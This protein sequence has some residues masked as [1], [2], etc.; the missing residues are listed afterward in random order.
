MH[1]LVRGLAGSFA[2]AITGEPLEEPIDLEL[3]RQQHDSYVE[4]LKSLVSSVTELPADDAHPG[5]ELGWAML[6]GRQRAARSSSASRPLCRVRLTIPCLPCF[7]LPTAATDCCFIEDT[8]VVA[9]DTAVVTRI[10]AGPRQGEEAPVAE[11]LQALGLRLVRVEAPATLDG[12]DVLQLPGGNTI[13]VGLSRRTNPAGVV[14]LASALP[15][16]SVHGVPVEQGLHLKSL[17]TALDASTLLIADTPA[18]RALGAVLPPLGGRWEQVFVPDA[19]CANVLLLNGG[20][21]V[22]AQGGFPASEALLEGLCTARGL[23][24]HKIPKLTE[25]IK[26]DGALTCCSILLPDAA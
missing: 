18:G 7:L 19:V 26:A 22:V 13:L 10:G 1:A 15:A 16:A 2:D 6:P 17:L 3:A 23:R 21:D 8:A 5:K 20:R 25:M 24:L 12:G 11:A 14:A 4:V 9:G